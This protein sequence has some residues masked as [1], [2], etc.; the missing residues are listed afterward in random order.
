MPDSPA[1]LGQLAP[2]V[3]TSLR[4]G[5]ARQRA[6]AWR[7]FRALLDPGKLAREVQVER[8]AWRAAL[9][10]WSEWISNPAHPEVPLE[11]QV[12]VLRLV[13][14][15]EPG[16]ETTRL[17]LDLAGGSYRGAAVD[18][19]L[20]G[21]ALYFLRW[22]CL[23]V[24]L[25]AWI[26]I[27]KDVFTAILDDPQSRVRQWGAYALGILGEQGRQN[28]EPGPRGCLVGDDAYTAVESLLIERWD[29]EIDAYV[30]RQLVISLG[31]TG[32]HGGLPTLSNWA[33]SLARVFEKAA[34]HENG[35]VSRHVPDAIFSV[36]ATLSSVNSASLEEKS[37]ALKRLADGLARWLRRALA[38]H[39]DHHTPQDCRPFD[40]LSCREKVAIGLDRLTAV[41]E[42]GL[43]LYTSANSA[44]RERLAKIVQVLFGSTAHVLASP[45]LEYDAYREA[46]QTI[47][48]FTP[49]AYAQEDGETRGLP[50]LEAALDGLKTLLDTAEAETRDESVA[51]RAVSAVRFLVDS[52]LPAR[53][54]CRIWLR[55]QEAPAIPRLHALLADPRPGL[56][57][58]ACDALILIL[59]GKPAA[60][61]F[62]HVILE[63]R[64]CQ[65]I[66]A[67]YRTLRKGQVAEANHLESAV[68][69]QAAM[70]I[71]RIPDNQE[72]K[73]RL[74]DALRLRE[75]PAYQRAYDALVQM[76]DRQSVET[77]IEIRKQ[78]WLESRYFNP[79]D[80]VNRHGQ[81]ILDRMVSQ[82]SVSFYATLVGALLVMGAGIALMWLS[83]D[84]LRTERG[85]TLT[86]TLS[87][88]AGALTT[89]GG[90]LVPFIFNPTGHVQKAN[91][92]IARL[93][94]AFHGYIGRARLLG[95]GFAHQ[96]TEEKPD[97]AFLTGI[98]DAI[99]DAMTD[100]AGILMDVASRTRPGGDNP[101][102][103]AG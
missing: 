77:L 92:E 32:G 76:G 55:Q 79:I 24:D 1:L 17:L 37:A 94:T 21:W 16:D 56:A 15:V 46:I 39:K 25:Q 42:K 4:A 61:F 74:R 35:I 67:A 47:A 103:N 66:V 40:Q 34:D 18:S 83:I 30:A 14:L 69:S 59:G 75:G 100:S 2:L 12:A 60:D 78:D 99:G 9:D 63:E 85:E 48:E 70:A 65:E 22:S 49:R 71:A 90:M 95:L 36:A 53:R 10:E 33:W 87:A 41:V 82:S 19:D 51:L 101:G 98:S 8:P 13:T 97:L 58:G 52:D 6:T 43:D 45:G 57:A 26:N 93:L 31:Q 81:M 68:R 72:A 28:D 86:A 84:V 20:R 5:D 102:N 50:F 7:D 3:N 89:L 73:D 44:E 91:A 11:A 23:E 27:Y 54:A 29:K 96:Y 38:V 80:D 62:S 88:F 64:P